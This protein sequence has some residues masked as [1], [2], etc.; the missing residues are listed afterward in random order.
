MGLL[1]VKTM[2]KQCQVSL[3]TKNS[4][5]NY[6]QSYSTGIISGVVTP[7]DKGAEAKP[8]YQHDFKN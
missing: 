4:N 5:K 3:A 1:H 6:K 2:Q 7:E 8:P